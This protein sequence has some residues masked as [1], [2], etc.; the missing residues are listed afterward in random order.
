MLFRSI[1]CIGLG[2]VDYKA[3]R[4]LCPQEFPACTNSD[5][6]EDDEQVTPII[7]TSGNVEYRVK[8]LLWFPLCDIVKKLVV[9]RQTLNRL[10]FPVTLF[11][12]KEDQFIAKLMNLGLQK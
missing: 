7:V 2:Q 8:M 5:D 11:I 9:R 12:D 1:T 10:L 6:Y 3:F 4:Q